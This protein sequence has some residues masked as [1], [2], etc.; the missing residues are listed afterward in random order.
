MRKI[1][2]TIVEFPCEEGLRD[3]HYEVILARRDLCDGIEEQSYPRIEN[4]VTLYHS[5]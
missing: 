4:L 3:T 1:V 5:G 2:V